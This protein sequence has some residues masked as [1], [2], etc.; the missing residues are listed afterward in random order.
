MKTEIVEI[1]GELGI[2]LPDEI[3]NRLKLNA[4]SDVVLIENA[5]SITITTIENINIAN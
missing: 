2:I 3:V 1:N 4:D 5:N